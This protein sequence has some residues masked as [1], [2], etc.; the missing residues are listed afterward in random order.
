M[1]SV[2][3]A[4]FARD[5]PGANVPLEN[6][7]AG[8]VWTG[9][10]VVGILTLII[11]LFH[12]NETWM[13]RI[14]ITVLAMAGL[15]HRPL[16]RRAAFWWLITA[17]LVTI[18]SL[19]WDLWLVNHKYAM[20]YWCLAMACAM[21]VDTPRE[22]M[23]VNARLLIGWFFLFA[24]FWKIY[25]PEFMDG[26]FFHFVF[27]SDHRFLNVAEAIG[28]MPRELAIENLAAIDQLKQ[29]DVVPQPVTLTDTP[30]I[31]PMALFMAW[32]TIVIE[33][34]LA[35]LFLWPAQGKF[36]QWRSAILLAFCVT[37]FPI[38]TVQGFAALL[39]MMGYAQCEPTST[40]L[41]LAFL[42]LF[43]ILPLF[44]LPTAQFLRTIF[45]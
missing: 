23:A 16:I 35:V 26:S 37:T 4:D 42:A 39:A 43:L 10:D 38:A 31:A 3:T 30:W 18:Y 29:F 17:I 25:S 19:N 15:V 13:L 20:T 40:R 12:A 44:D 2:T 33:G 14:P 21:S 34:M 5:V 22:V 6:E 1:S 24:T 7:D 45:G 27:L 36:V 41:R 32:W 8:H 28:G 11:L 9:V